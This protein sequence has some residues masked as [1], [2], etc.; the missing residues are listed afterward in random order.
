MADPPMRQWPS[1]D[2]DKGHTAIDK[3]RVKKL[4]AALVQ[5]LKQYEGESTA[6]TPYGVS[7]ALSQITPVSVGASGTGQTVKGQY[8]SS[9][10][11]GELMYR[12]VQSVNGSAV[13]GGGAN[14]EGFTGE[15]SNFVTQYSQVIDA[16]YKA[17]GIQEDADTQS[18]LQ[19]GGGSGTTLPT[20]T[21]DGSSGNNGGSYDN[22]SQT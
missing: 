22:G 15:Y 3:E 20:T 10:P 14:G 6:G 21:N 4:L 5:D 7:D 19:A 13:A 17:A 12:A 1:V 16:L 9:Y 2:G 18:I 11:G 8:S